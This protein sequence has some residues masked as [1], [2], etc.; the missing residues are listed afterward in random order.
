MNPSFS[1]RRKA[2]LGQSPAFD[3]IKISHCGETVGFLAR[4]PEAGGRG[5]S[6]ER[7][8]GSW[9]ERKKATLKITNH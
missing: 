2:S 9:Q 6:L 3:R 8:S 1:A 5:E 7:V 4:A